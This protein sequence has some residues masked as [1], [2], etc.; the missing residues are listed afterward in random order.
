MIEEPGQRQVNNRDS[1]RD[2]IEMDRYEDN[3]ITIM[4]RGDNDDAQDNLSTPQGPMTIM[5]PAPVPL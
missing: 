1:D 2:H 5:A 4:R 3:G